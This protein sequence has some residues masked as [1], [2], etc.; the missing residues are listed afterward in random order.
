MI[1]AVPVGAGQV[2]AAPRRACRAADGWSLAGEALT[3]AGRAAIR[4]RA[5]RCRGSV[6][7]YGPDRGDG[8]RHGLASPAGDAGPVPPIGRPIWNTRVYVLDERLGLV[9]PG[10]A[11]ELYLAGAG[12]RGGTWAGRG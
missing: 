2:L 6:N 11:G 9:P 3:A 5:A 12:W 4:C 10:V 7:I 1:S 8:L